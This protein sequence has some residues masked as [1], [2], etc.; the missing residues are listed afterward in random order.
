MPLYEFRCPDGTLLEAAFSM[1]TVPDAVDCPECG[2]PATRRI[3]SVRLSRAG[4]SA[5]RL[6]ESTQRSASAP[7]VVTALPTAGRAPRD[8]PRYTGNPLHRK[9]PRP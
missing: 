4:S 9:L 8:G 2:A 5:Y 3:T 6:I 7:E 1:A